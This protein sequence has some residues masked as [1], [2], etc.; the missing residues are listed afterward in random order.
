M[1]W[2][3]EIYNYRSAR[4]YQRERHESRVYDSALAILHVGYMDKHLHSLLRSK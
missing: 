3:S 1:H 4:R 2:V